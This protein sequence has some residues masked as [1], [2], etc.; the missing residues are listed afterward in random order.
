M[1][2]RAKTTIVKLVSACTSAVQIYHL[3]SLTVTG[4]IPFEKPWR[5][6]LVAKTSASLYDTRSS[7]SATTSEEIY[8]HTKADLVAPFAICISDG[9]S[10]CRVFRG[11]RLIRLD[12]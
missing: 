2:A 5:L 3:S 11:L 8:G 1:Q 12:L 6:Q 4:K 9:R 10:V 7:N